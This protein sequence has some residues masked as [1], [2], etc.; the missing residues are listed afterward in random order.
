M[1][2]IMV[3]EACNL[4]CPYCFAEEFINKAPKEMKLEDFRVAL[5]FILSDNSERQ[6]GIIGGEPLLYTHINEAVRIA[7][8]DPRTEIVMIFTN[9]VELERLS[10]DIL[11]SKNFACS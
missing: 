7:L 11:E 5:D 4:R 10:P 6:V 8:D 1:A 2:N 9:A 3:N